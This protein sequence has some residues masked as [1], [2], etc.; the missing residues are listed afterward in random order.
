MTTCFR[1]IGER[2]KPEELKNLANMAEQESSRKEGVDQGHAIYDL[3]RSTALFKAKLQAIDPD[4][5]SIC[6][7]QSIFRYDVRS[8]EFN[9]GEGTLAV[10]RRSSSVR[11]IV[12]IS[13]ISRAYPTKI[14]R[15]GSVTLEA[16]EEMASTA[17]V[18][19]L[20]SPY[21]LPVNPDQLRYVP[22]DV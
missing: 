12:R 5:S 14:Y 18:I 13:H 4:K 7:D 19:S 21:S 16:T 1:A 10:S 2:N 6:H 15:N 3:L 17:S 9:D 11:Y 8:W 20:S 22:E